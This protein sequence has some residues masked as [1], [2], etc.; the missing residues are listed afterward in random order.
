MY[1]PGFRVDRYT[2]LGTIDRH[3]FWFVARR[4]IIHWLLREFA[5]DDMSLLL[6]AG[7]G[8]GLNLSLLSEFGDTVL[9]VDIWAGLCGGT[10]DD[11]AIPGDLIRAEITRLPLDDASVDT[12]LALDVLEHVDDQAATL[13]LHRV[14]NYGGMLLV[15]VPAFSWLWSFRDEDAGHLRRYNMR[16]ISELLHDNGFEL[17]YSSYYQFM[18]F[19]LLIVSRLFARLL[20]RK[21]K[22]LRDLEDSPPTL[23][24]SVLSRINLTE[25]SWLQANKQRRLPWGSSIVLVARKISSGVV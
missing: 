16:Q 21:G 14:L 12:V 23:V 6:D 24:Q 4:E 5:H 17:I 1:S 9:G 8:S 22:G 7:C 15:T 11:S 3:H 13:E 19:P 18:L 10:D 25:V 20:L 2:K